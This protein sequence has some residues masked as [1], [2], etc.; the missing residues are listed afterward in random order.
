[1]LFCLEQSILKSLS[2]NFSRRVPALTVCV[3]SSYN[4]PPTKTDKWECCSL[5][6]GF[7]FALRGRTFLLSFCVTVTFGTKVWQ[8]TKVFLTRGYSREVHVPA[9]AS[10]TTYRRRQHRTFKTPKLSM[11]F[12]YRCRVRIGP[13]NRAFSLG[14]AGVIS[15]L[16]VPYHR[17]QSGIKPDQR[18]IRPT[19]SHILSPV[20]VLPRKRAKVFL[21]EGELFEHDPVFDDVPRACS[22]E[23]FRIVLVLKR[24]WFS[25]LSAAIDPLTE[26]L[27]LSSQTVTAGKVS[28]G[29]SR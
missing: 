14:E 27:I 9:S 22:R 10:A 23:C 13:K 29:S 16:A 12:P 28:S 1:M 2:A 5:G 24:S 4:A 3:S 11:W 20:S 19:G 26:S 15:D 8:R 17:F 25:P 21:L 7:G 18:S 6:V